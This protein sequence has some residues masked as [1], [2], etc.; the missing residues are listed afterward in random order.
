MTMTASL[1]YPIGTPGIPWGAAERAVWL[2]R[3]RKQRSYADDVLG[4]VE[5]MRA[6]FEVIDYGRIEYGSETYPLVA[7]RSLVGATT[8]P[9]CW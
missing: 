7:L 5:R 9:S 4:A 8:C 6:R 2:S 3:Q 1:P